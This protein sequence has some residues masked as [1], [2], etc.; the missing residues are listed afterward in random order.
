MTKSHHG[1]EKWETTAK[2]RA[3]K[4]EETTKFLEAQ[5][6]RVVEMKECHFRNQ[7]RFDPR[8]KAFVE[9]RKPQTPQ[10]EMTENEIKAAVLDGT[11]FGMVEVDIKVPEEWPTH[12]QHPN[13]TPYEYFAEMSPIFC[14]TEVPHDIIGEHMQEYVKK[15]DLSTKPRRLL[16]GGMRAQKILLATPLLKWY[17]E[18]GLEVTKIYQ[19]VEYKPNRCF[20]EFVKDV[21]NARRAGDADPSKA[22]IADTRKLEGNSAF[23]SIIMDQHKF[24]DTVYVKGDGPAMLEANLPQFKKLT[25]LNEEFYEIEKAK[26]TLRL[27][28]PV[29]IGYFILQYAKLHMLQFYYDFLDK[30]VDRS[31]FEYCEMDTDSAYMALATPDFLS[32]VKPEM[33]E[34]YLR[35][36]QGHCQSGL[37]IEAD[38]QHHWFPRSCC[39]QHAKF[40]KRTP[41]LFKIEYEGDAMIGLC[42]KTYVVAK[43]V[44]TLPS[45]SILSASRLLRKAKRL[46]PKRL[47]LVTRTYFEKKFS[48]KGISKKTVVAPLTIFRQVLKTQKPGSG[49]NRGFRARNNTIF[50]YKQQRCGF[51]YFY[52][53]RKVLAEGRTTVP[54]DLELCPKPMEVDEVPTQEEPMEVEAGAEPMEVDGE[55]EPMESL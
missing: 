48:S 53:K 14:T 35:G 32:A 4:T 45:N 3:Q 37:Q 42:S 24:Q 40:D 17:L 7:M 1:K 9:A 25:E 43:K 13:M 5:G 30:F 15:F 12:F 39:Q 41:G 38:C 2:T 21:S 10:R 49:T 46:R 51:S 34:H 33:K 16:V 19:T 47:R 20:Q 29:Q 27:N 22:I 11:L 28:L 6:Y 26:T 18:H 55:K 52:C 8:L 44:S 23:G 31:D 50:T 54:L 36:L